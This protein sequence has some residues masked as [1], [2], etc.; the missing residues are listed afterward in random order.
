L[1]IRQG[2]KVLRWV[3]NPVTATLLAFSVGIVLFAGFR[4]RTARKRRTG[5]VPSP[6]THRPT[7]ARS[8]SLAPLAAGCLV[9]I[10]TAAVAFAQPLERRSERSVRYETTGRFR[11]ESDVAKS[12]VYPSGSVQTEDAL[13]LNLV[14][15]VEITFD[16]RL[17]ADAPHEIHG[18]SALVAE[19]SSP[20]GWKYTTRLQSKTTFQGD[21]EVVS[22]SLDLRA[23]NQLTSRV[24]QMTGV[25]ETSF[26]LTITPRVKFNGE[27]SGKPIEHVFAPPL[28]FEF[29]SL[30]ARLA[31]AE[32]PTDG[33]AEPSNPLRPT[34]GDS[35]RVPETIANSISA[36]PLTVP[37]EVVRLIAL[38]GAVLCALLAAAVFFISGR[39]ADDPDAIGRRYGKW[40]ID[41]ETLR[42][43]S[44]RTAIQVRGMDEL[45][46]LA[47]RYD[48]LILHHE[49]DGI[50]SYVVEE[51]N[52]AYWHQALVAE[53]QGDSN[54]TTL[55]T[56]SRTRRRQ[57]VASDRAEDVL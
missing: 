53:E 57:A 30:R 22:G 54:V 21:R 17:D 6:T 13:F 55:P 18:S 38:G 31:P 11:Y 50:H 42:P 8:A 34:A 7:G 25:E 52:I 37:V 49:E 56:R 16:A 19:I 12:P 5:T 48:R 2:G 40:M 43:T 28:K 27:V 47:E 10:S 32:T 45:V 51:A 36:G 41:V 9:F 20:A 23:L 1:V 3:G 24:Q 14:D 26:V 44:E 46:E 15:D 33:L 39:A 29:D 35:V 4:V